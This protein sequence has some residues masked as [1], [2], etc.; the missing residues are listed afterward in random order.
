M[1]EVID[2]WG[3]VGKYSEEE[4]KSLTIPLALF[5]KE[6]ITEMINLI[7][8]AQFCC[9]CGC[10]CSEDDDDGYHTRSASLLRKLYGLKYESKNP[11]KEA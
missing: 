4:M 9:G 7:D 5:T 6:V 10:C 8:E 2:V 1:A 3:R 11:K